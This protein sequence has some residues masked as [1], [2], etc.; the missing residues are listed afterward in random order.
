MKGLFEESMANIRELL[1]DSSRFAVTCDIW[2]SKFSDAFLMVTC[3]KDHIFEVITSSLATVKLSDSTKMANPN[4]ATAH[5][6]FSAT[7]F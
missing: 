3:H 5:A 4:Q 2:T 7:Q 6:S 1:K